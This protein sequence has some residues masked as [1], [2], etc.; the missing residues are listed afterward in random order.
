MEVSEQRDD[1][2]ERHQG[3]EPDDV[4]FAVPSKGAFALENEAISEQESHP[5][6]TT[7]V[8]GDVHHANSLR[9]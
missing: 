2:R 5:A 9:R 4:P 3:R 8:T 7:A 6:T 1:D